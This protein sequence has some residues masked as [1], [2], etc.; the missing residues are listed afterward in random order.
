MASTPS[1]SGT[2]AGLRA[3][4]R[5]G[6]SRAKCPV[7]PQLK[8]APRGRRAAG[9]AAAGFLGALLIGGELVLPE[10]APSCWEVVVRRDEASTS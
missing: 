8:Q 7:W 9:G 6:Q 1:G 2:A 3:W 4:S 10:V 5:L